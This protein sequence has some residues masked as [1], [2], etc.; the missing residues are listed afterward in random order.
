MV[1]PIIAY[2]FD[3]ELNQWFPIYETPP[4][5]IATRAFIQCYECQGVISSN[6]GP[7]YGAVCLTCWG[8]QRLFDFIE[9]RKND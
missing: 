6:G 1:Q 7:K 3:Y 5:S 4:G 9:R 8:N 2:R